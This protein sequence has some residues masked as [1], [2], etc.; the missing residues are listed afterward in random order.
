M[1]TEAGMSVDAFRTHL[2][3][4]LEETCKANGKTY[5]NN[6]ARGFAFQLW[7]SDLLLRVHDIDQAPD[8]TVFTTNDL[9]IDI[10]FDE[11]ETKTL[12]LSQTKHESGDVKESDV[13]DFF[14][15]HSI[16]LD[17]REWVREHASEEL[18]D[19]ISDYRQR[20]A[21]GW[22][23]NFYFISTGSASDRV[24]KLAAAMDV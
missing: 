5:D 14:L 21:E 3:R 17:Q 18:N 16:L 9:K 22:N 7:V 1:A 20:V 19:L 11:E 10:A 23:I 4:D 8:D 6:Q 15:R 24:K 12:C 2:R 13:T